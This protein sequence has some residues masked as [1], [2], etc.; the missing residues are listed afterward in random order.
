[1]PAKSGECLPCNQKNQL[2]TFVWQGV[3][4]QSL[5]HG[6]ITHKRRLLGAN[7]ARL[8]RRPKQGN[9]RQV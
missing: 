4:Y 1:M 2:W 7:A 3:T 9:A 8:M 5:S 6:K